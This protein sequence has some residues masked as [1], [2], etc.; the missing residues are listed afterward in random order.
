M[1]SEPAVC[2][3]EAY[4]S[5]ASNL[6]HLETTDGLL[7]AAVAIAMHGLPGTDPGNVDDVLLAYAARV[8]SRVRSHNV[9]AILAHVHHVLFV[10]EG[11]TGNRENY[12][13]A[14]NSYLPTVLHT[15][16]GIPVTLAVIYKVVAERAGLHVEGLNAPGHFL[17][18]VRGQRD[19]MIVDPFYGGDL[20]TRDEAFDRI[21]R[22]T[23][24]RIPHTREYL[25]KAT[26]AQW[27]SRILANL[28]NVLAAENR[29]SDLAAMSELQS[30]LEDAV[31]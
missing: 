25:P 23:G 13:C 27:I 2:R 9:Q 26:H 15:K 19:W 20:L 3:P 7:R 12:Y 11:F 14:G 6:P 8:R 5:F 22:V 16:R 21:E 17:V 18:R 28:Q 30:L 24:R 31:F 4:R 1:N 10:E 29:H